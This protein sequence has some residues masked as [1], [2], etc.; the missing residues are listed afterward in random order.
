MKHLLNFQAAAGLF[1]G[2]SMEESYLSYPMFNVVCPACENSRAD[3]PVTGS[4]RGV[5]PDLGVNPFLLTLCRALVTHTLPSL[6]LYGKSVHQR[7]PSRT[8]S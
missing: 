4:W 6:L 2:L 5:G 7:P 1:Q 3:R 8:G